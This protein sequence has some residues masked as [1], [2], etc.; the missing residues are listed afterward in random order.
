MG[1]IFKYLLLSL[2]GQSVCHFLCLQ[3]I[4]NHPL[5]QVIEVERVGIGLGKGWV[6]LLNPIP[7]PEV[8]PTE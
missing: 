3:Q 1:W 7:F 8:D 6:W 4:R 5:I 2:V